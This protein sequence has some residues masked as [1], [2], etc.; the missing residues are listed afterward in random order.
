MN[1]VARLWRNHN[2]ALLV[3]LLLLLTMGTLNVF[4]ASFVTAGQ[5]MKDSYF[6][7]KRHLLSMAVGSFVFFL[8]A[9]VKYQGKMR[10]S[11]TLFW[12]FCLAV[13]ALV[14]VYGVTFIGS[15]R[16][17]RLA[18]FTVQPSE[19]AKLSAV[20]L[21]AASLGIQT[22]RRRLSTI[23]S[24]AL[25]A[26]VFL[27]LPVYFQPDMGTAA[28]IIALPL[29]MH[30]VAGVAG[31][32]WLFLL[33]LGGLGLTKLV[34][35]EGYRAE[36]IA[37]WLNP[38]QYAQDQGYQ[39]VQ[40]LLAIGSGGLTGTG[41]GQGM[42]KF[43]YLPE[44]HTD[45]AFA[46]FAQEWGLGGAWFLIFLFVLLLVYGG[47]IV[48][49]APDTLSQMLALG[50]LLLIVGQAAGNLLMVLGLLPVIGVPLP[51]ISYGGT[52]LIVNMAAMGLLLNIGRQ[53]VAAE[54]RPASEEVQL[55]AEEQGL[56]EKLERKRHLRLVR[57]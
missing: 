9:K 26:A 37:S 44:A 17:M 54:G 21:A 1:I 48:R 25:V 12:I 14:H 3:I 52:S 51:F 28:L 43:F 19:L 4:S 2:E 5:E 55:T 27:A 40:A 39:A 57:H 18:S 35:A 46:V 16:W 13:L 29:V 15:R 22:R 50:C 42:G 6:L 24:P 36:R 10:L 49:K 11:A 8:M 33:F 45:F 34:M 41:P 47:Q 38:W 30:L 20:F 56:K 7:F 31:W 32:Q 23:F 53:V